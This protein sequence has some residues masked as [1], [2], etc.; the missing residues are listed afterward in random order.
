MT[1]NS[2]TDHKK[3]IMNQVL[4]DAVTL[5]L[6]YTDSMLV[7]G[8]PEDECG[9]WLCLGTRSVRPEVLLAWETETGQGK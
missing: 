6:D 5:L 2:L 7:P 9:C 4:E 3:D 1:V 8:G